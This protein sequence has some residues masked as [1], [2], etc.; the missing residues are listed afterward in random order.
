MGIS[1][2]VFVPC[3]GPRF[4]MLAK[5]EARSKGPLDLFGSMRVTEELEKEIIFVFVVFLK[6]TS[7]FGP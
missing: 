3:V 2:R 7:I 4:F 5:I 6:T 1:Q